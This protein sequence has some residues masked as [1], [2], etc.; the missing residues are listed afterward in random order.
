M[1]VVLAAAAAA[2]AFI[3]VPAQAVTAYI[4]PASGGYLVPAAE[5]YRFAPP[6]QGHRSVTAAY[7]AMGSLAGSL[8]MM[9]FPSMWGRSA[10]W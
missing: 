10:G 1:K 2:A 7:T 9:A 3:S 4:A 6:P 5:L 8:Y